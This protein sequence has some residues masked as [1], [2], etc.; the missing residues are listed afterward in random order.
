MAVVAVA[1]IVH[2]FVM[3][4]NNLIPY[5]SAKNDPFV[6]KHK[7][8]DLFIYNELDTVRREVDFHRVHL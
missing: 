1:A 7:A 8:L 2:G 4:A 5:K 3:G 6:G